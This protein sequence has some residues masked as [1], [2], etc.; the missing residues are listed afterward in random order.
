MQLQGANGDTTRVKVF[1]VVS[2]NHYGNFDRWG[3]FPPATKKFRQIIMKYTV[4]CE[5]NGQ[6]E[7]DYTNTIYVRKNTGLKD[8]TQQKATSF[9]VNNQVMDSVNYAT[10]TTW[11]NV[12]NA[13]TKKTDSV[14]SAPFIIVRYN[15]VN[16]R[17]PEVYQD[18]LKV[19]PV[20]Y[21]RY[22][23]DTTGKK[24]DSVFVPVAHT[25]KAVYTNYYSVFDR[26]ED[27]EMGRMITPYAVNGSLP[28]PF[29]YEYV[30][31]VTDYAT[32]LHDSAQIRMMY[33]G[34]S[35][36]FTGT[37]EFI[38]IEGTPAREA[39]KVENLWNGYFPYG[40]TS[41]PI[42]N[43]LKP[44]TFTKDASAASIKLRMTIT[45]HGGEKNENCS[46][47]CEKYYILN[48]NG[49]Q[50]EKRSI[51][52]DKCG[53]NPII[54]QG[55]T[56]IYDRANWCPGALTRPYE[57]N[58]AA[59]SGTN[60]LDIS[61]EDFTANGS[62]GYQYGTQ[63]IY[64]KNNSFNVDATIDA[65]LAPTKEF[66]YSRTNPI[67]DNAKIML[68]NTGT[69]ALT[70]AVI[71][72][73]VGDGTPQSYN[74]S[75]NLAFDQA[76]EVVLPQ[77]NWVSTSNANTFKV[78]IDKA[79]GQTDENPFND[80]RTSTFDLPPVLPFTFVIETRTNNNPQENS[81]TITAAPGWNVM[82]RTFDQANKL[83]RDT[84]TLGYGCFTLRFEDT[85]KN[86][87][88]F[89]AATAQGSGTLRIVKIP[90]SVIKTFNPDF[91]TFVEYHFRV[92]TPVGIEEAH[93]DA[94]SVTLYPQ[95]ANDRLHI[96]SGDVVLTRAELVSLDGRHILTFTEEQLTS[97]ELDLTG[98]QPGV[99]L[100]QLIAGNGQQLVKK[101]SIVK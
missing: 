14:P 18:S 71:K 95:P 39:Y 8:S 69:Q 28:R 52:T 16:A 86:G 53:S 58:L 57:Y 97:G 44:Q 77:M 73:Q 30:Y 20:Q 41:D 32:L 19:W 49:S 59:N 5:S 68:R 99:F 6:C 11:V 74:W 10:D 50:L 1:D 79:N 4:S 15:F 12:Y 2:F 25:L 46:E 90:T 64:Y 70:S 7:W 80:T 84:I 88:S 34:Y 29:A 92:G 87:L 40:N 98:V 96:S 42:S 55:G 54:N 35:W 67:C 66:V 78:W 100:L 9:R 23:Y 91:G 22:K 27:Y 24:T 89:W 60:T 37:I 93:Y 26:I 72:Y 83:H 17:N 101:V 85:E 45:G 21:Y 33:S 31:D 76:M 61:M 51:W 48:L 38:M 94:A 82:T 13:S 43:Y 3:V 36:G 81:Y 75:G 47:F 63:L 62:A 65:I 56:W